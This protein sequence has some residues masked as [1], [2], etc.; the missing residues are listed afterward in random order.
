MDIVERFDPRLGK[1]QVVAPMSTR[2]KHLGVAVFTPGIPG[3]T[4]AAAPAALAAL[5]SVA[6]IYAVG[7]RDDVTE[8]ST[9]ERYCPQTNSWL[10]ILPMTNR[11]S[12][13]FRLHRN[14]CSLTYSM[15]YSLVS[16]LVGLRS[17]YTSILCGIVEYLCTT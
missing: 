16:L 15:T 9:A 12:G 5:S 14:T 1:W 17:T 4:Y 11:R 3:S 8:L 2:R 7:G 10:S 13:V 6:G